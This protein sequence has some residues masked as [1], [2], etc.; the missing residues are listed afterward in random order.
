MS[1]RNDLVG[2]F[3]GL[4][5]ISRAAVDHKGGELYKTWQNSSLRDL[6]KEAGLKLESK[7]GN[8]KNIKSQS[9][10]VSGQTRVNF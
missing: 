8:A 2:F 1:R 10:Q 4:Q 6:T 9:L 3:R 5:Q 7:L